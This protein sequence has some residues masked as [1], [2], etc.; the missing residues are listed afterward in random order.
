MGDSHGVTE[1][2]LSK[3]VTYVVSSNKEAKRGRAGTGDGKQSNPTSGDTNPTSSGPAACRGNPPR[4][5]QKPPDTA[6]LSRG[7]ELLQKAMKRQDACSGSSIL[8]NARLWG[9]QILHVDEMVSYAQQ[10]LRDISGARKHCQKTERRCLAPGSKIHKAARILRHLRAAFLHTDSTSSEEVSRNIMHPAEES[11]FLQPT[12]CCRAE[13][14]IRKLKPPFLKVEDQSRQFRPFHHQFQSFPHLNFLAPKSCSPFE[15]LKSLSN[16]CQAR[17]AEGSDGGRSPCSTAAPRKRR[18]F[19]ECCQETFEELQKHLQSPRHQRFARDDSQYLPVDRVISQ[20]TNS[21][22]QRSDRVPQSCLADEHLVP[23]AHGTGRVEMLTELGKE[24]EQPEQGAVEL[25]MDM[26]QDHDLEIKGCSPCLPGDRVRDPREGGGLS[27]QGSVGLPRGAELSG[28]VCAA[29]GTTEGAG[30]GPAGLGSAPA[31][32][33]ESCAAAAPP[34]EPR[35]QQVPG[36]VSHPPAALPVP[37]KRQLSPSQSSQV[38]KRPRLE[39]GQQTGPVRGGLGAEGAGQMSGPGLP[40]VP[41]AGRLALHTQ[42]CSRPRG[43][44]ALD[45]CP[46]GSPGDPGSPGAGDAAGAAPAGEGGWSGAG[47]RPAGQQLRGGDGATPGRASSPGLESTA[48]GRSS[49]PAGRP[50]VA[51]ARCCCSVCVGAAEKASPEAAELPGHSAERAPCP[52]LL[53]PPAPS[54]RSFGGSSSECDWDVPLLRGVQGSRMAAVDRDELHRTQ[55]S[56]RDSGYECR[57]RSVLRRDPQPGWA[58]QDSG[59]CRTCCTGTTA[60]PFPLLETFCGSWTS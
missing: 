37:R 3:E 55:G 33:W 54:T 9:V 10:L 51:G 49:C 48:S 21:F 18:G 42:L 40:G 50:P 29:H 20:L 60:P 2:F 4:P 46:G 47:V 32:G 13:I 45:A 30:L 39:Q 5:H 41:G 58:A 15:P 16:P 44:L 1:S 6:L 7:K 38:G 12:H 34:S 31:L 17:G 26:E 57:L 22:L 11:V 23:Q 19:C 35:G 43:S 24:R 27:E 56:G 8:A 14:Q 53:P 28:G 36:S 52:G 59:S 25:V